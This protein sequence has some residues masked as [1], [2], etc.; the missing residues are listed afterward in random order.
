MAVDKRGGEGH[1]LRCLR[2]VKGS[3]TDFDLVLESYW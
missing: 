1:I 2:E 3:H